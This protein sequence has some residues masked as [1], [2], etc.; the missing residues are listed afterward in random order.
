[1]KKYLS[2][3][4][5]VLIFTAFCNSQENNPPFSNE[6]F[7]KYKNVTM[8]LGYSSLSDVKGLYEPYK[9]EKL[10]HGGED[11]YW[12]NMIRQIYFNNKLK[13]IFSVEK[14]RLIQIV[15][16][17]EKGDKYTMFCGISEKNNRDQILEIFESKKMKLSFTETSTFW[18][19]YLETDDFNVICGFQFDNEGKIEAINFHIDAPW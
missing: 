10:K 14:D 18:V 16:I 4:F 19:D 2:I 5:M 13:L 6:I 7:L 8:I 3:I 1:M 11:F 15:F 9:S 17:P 12:E